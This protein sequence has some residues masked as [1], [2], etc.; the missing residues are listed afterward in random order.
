MKKI[1]RILSFVLITSYISTSVVFADTNNSTNSST[2]SEVETSTETLK[3]VDIRELAEHIKDKLVVYG[4]PQTYVGNVIEH[5]QK[6][7]VSE[8]Q[9]IEIENKFKEVESLLGN[10]YDL[11]RL[12]EERKKAMKN[13]MIET[14]KLV[15]FRVVFGKDSR[16]VT[17]A[18][19]TDYNGVIIAELNT[20]HVIE[21]VL[22]MDSIE[23]RNF[24]EDVIEFVN[25]SYKKEFNPIQ[26]EFNDTGSNVA[27]EIMIGSSLTILAFVTFFV[28]RFISRKVSIE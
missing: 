6:I 26:G 15:G 2:Q 24:A 8:E 9:I 1:L 20:F 23:M 14:A 4:L 27:N 3:E 28:S 13:L 18:I 12:D 25:T 10:Q 17:T 19:L 21:L 16:G 22:N 11:S 5:L 7:D